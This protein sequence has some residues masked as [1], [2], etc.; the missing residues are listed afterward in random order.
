MEARARHGLE[1]GHRD[2][3]ARPLAAARA[4]EGRTRVSFRFAYGVA[5]GGIAGLI[6]ERVAARSLRRRFRHSLLNLKRDLESRRFDGQAERPAEL[7]S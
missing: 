5:G 7:A 4:G 3:P 1:L 6:A 2:R